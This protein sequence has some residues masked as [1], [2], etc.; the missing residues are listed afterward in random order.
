MQ[1]I[2]YYVKVISLCRQ[3]SELSYANVWIDAVSMNLIS[4]KWFQGTSFLPGSQANANV[5]KVGQ[6]RLQPG[7]EQEGHP[8]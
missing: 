4:T 6:Y 1:L 5:K 2:K 8:T 3:E 7:I